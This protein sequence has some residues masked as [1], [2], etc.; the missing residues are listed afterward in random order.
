MINILDENIKVGSSVHYINNGVIEN[1]VIKEIV[2][3]TQVRVVYNCGG[4]WGRY[5]EFTSALTDVSDLFKGWHNEA[6]NK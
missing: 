1:G 3:P 4:E 6:I 2:S 5:K